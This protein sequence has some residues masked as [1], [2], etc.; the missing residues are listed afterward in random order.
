MSLFETNTLPSVS[1]AR[2]FNCGRVVG[3]EV[4]FNMNGVNRVVRGISSSPK[5]AETEIFKKM[6][7]LEKSA[8][9]LYKNASEIK[10]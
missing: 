6:T 4:G 10:W 1:C 8:F 9:V 7:P 2:S 3:M 5:K